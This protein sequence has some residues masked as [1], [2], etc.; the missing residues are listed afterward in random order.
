MQN[1]EGNK[2]AKKLDIVWN[3]TS[4]CMWDCGVCCVDANHVIAKNKNI[5]IKSNNLKQKEYITNNKAQGSIFEQALKHRVALGLELSLEQ[6]LK[7]IENLKPYDVKMDFSGGDPLA[8][9]ETT[10]VIQKYSESF[11][12]E[13]VTLTAT[14]AGLTRV[15]PK[16]IIDYVGELNFTYDTPTLINEEC[17]P[18]G[19]AASNLKRAAQFAS[20]GVKV[21]GE[22]PLTIDNV[23]KTT[24]TKIYMDLHHASISTHLIMRLF[25]SGRGKFMEHKIPS[26]RQ[27]QEAI[28]HLYFLESQYKYPKIKLQCALK[29]LDKRLHE[30]NPCDMATE[31]FGLLPNGTLLA[32]PWAI[33]PHGLPVDEMFILGN[34]VDTPMSEILASDNC[35]NF[36]KNADLNFGHCKMQSYF[37]GKDRQERRDR[38]FAPSDPLY[39]NR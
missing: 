35:R 34:L 22:T 38:V 7:V 24:L 18:K 15:I 33:G 3:I 27:Y 9:K 36:I 5:L 29:F 39:T 19:Y 20:R 11:G 31:S 13:N 14:G 4:L 30:K 8:I 28:E 25:P 16:D 23:D 32:S 2:L 10:K 21:R 26:L 12:R 17:R 1:K 6:K 37:K